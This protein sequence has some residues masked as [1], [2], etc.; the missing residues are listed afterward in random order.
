[1]LAT[2]GWPQYPGYATIPGHNSDV[3]GVA[4]TLNWWK[5]ESGGMHTCAI[6]RYFNRSKHQSSDADFDH[7]SPDDAPGQ[8]RCWGMNDY[9][10]V[11]PLPLPFGEPPTEDRRDEKGRYPS[12]DFI[13]CLTSTRMHLL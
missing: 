6:R 5:V 1:M 3:Q 10:Q 11:H 2:N 9:G 8:L 4:S 13:P 12:K 7:P